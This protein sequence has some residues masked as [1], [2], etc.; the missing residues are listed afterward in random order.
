MANSSEKS[1]SA[2]RRAQTH[3]TASEQ[4]NTLVR[5]EIEKERAAGIAK[6]MKLR[7][8]RL[9]KEIADKEA[10]EK[11]ATEKKA[12]VSAKAASKAKAR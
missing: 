5:Q 1:D 8:L 7:T 12:A 3:F 4:R 11:L 10:K 9:A 2:R 6:I